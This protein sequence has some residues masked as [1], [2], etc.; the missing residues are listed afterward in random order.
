AAGLRAAS[1]G[2]ALQ[3]ASDVQAET[4]LGMRG[5]VEGEAFW[6][7][8]PDYVARA[9]GLASPAGLEDFVAR[10]GTVIGLAARSG[11]LGLFRL[12][13]QLREE[14]AVLTS[15]L[16]AEG[17]GMCVLSGDAPTVVASVAGKLGIGDAQGGLSPQGK[18][19]AI[20]AMQD[21]PDAV[22]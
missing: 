20:A 9:A 8:R 14:A 18:Q 1:A 4:G 12:A 2:Q 22:I 3:T 13:D 17:I 16:A 5:V 19:Q 6:I 10:G 11:W 15:R 7:G 21:D